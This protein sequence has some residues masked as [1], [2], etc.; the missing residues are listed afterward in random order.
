MYYSLYM[1]NIHVLQ[2]TYEWWR[3]GSLFNINNLP[4]EMASR[5]TFSND[6]RVVMWSSVDRVVDSGMYQCSASNSL[7]TTYSSAQMTVLCKYVTISCMHVYTF[8]RFVGRTT[9]LL[10][11]GL[12]KEL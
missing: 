11:L 5:V 2:P 10:V 9:Q 4:A 1:I 6:N 8:T 7:D 3:N 12:G